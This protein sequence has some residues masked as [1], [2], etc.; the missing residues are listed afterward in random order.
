MTGMMSQIRSIFWL[1]I[2]GWGT[3]FGAEE[4]PEPWA[5]GVE[6]PEDVGVD[7]PLKSGNMLHL[8]VV[9]KQFSAVFIDAERK[10][11]EPEAKRL[12][13]RGEEAQNK[14]S[15][16]NLVLKLSDAVTLSHPRRLFPPYDYWL[17]AL[18]GD[19]PGEYSEK[20]ARFRF[21]QD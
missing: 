5:L 2:L 1:L 17:I 14:T 7:V 20:L 16:I 13:L 19:G 11:V 9:D 15:E 18:L 4:A 6:V 10:I 21:T 12:I 3:V 8:E